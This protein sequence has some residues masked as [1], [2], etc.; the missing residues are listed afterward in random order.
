MARLRRS[1]CFWSKSPDQVAEQHFGHRFRPGPFA[2]EISSHKCG[3]GFRDFHSRR[4]DESSR[5]SFRTSSFSR[6]LRF[7]D[8][9]TADSSGKAAAYSASARAFI[10]QKFRKAGFDPAPSF[11]TPSGSENYF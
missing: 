3:K 9:Q 10:E 4:W 5:T 7:H 1:Q 11:F 2:D 8:R 6:F